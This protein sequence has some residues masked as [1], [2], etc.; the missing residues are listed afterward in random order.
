MN[1]ASTIITGLADSSSAHSIMASFVGPVVSTMCV[2]ASLACV[3]FLI[4]GGLTYMTSAGKPESLDHAKRVLKNALI[5]LI[6]VLAAGVLVQILTHAY[7]GSSVAIS[8]KLPNLTPVTPNPVSN[9][10]IDILIKAI[11][12]FLN[13]IIQ[14]IATPFL[15]AL[16]FF[17]SH[18]P[19]MADNSAVFNLWLAIVGITDALFVLVVA[20]LGFHVMSMSTFG[21][22]EIE[23]KHFVPRLALIFLGVNLSIFAID[24]IIELSNAMIHAIT[25]ISASTNIWNTMTD[26]VKQSGGAGVATLLVMVTFLIL[27]FILLVY[28]VGRIVALYV[29]AVLSPLVLML[30]LIP[31]FKDFS[32]TAAKVYISIIFV[33]FVNVIILELAASLFAGLVA[34]S[35]TH[36]P[37]T[38]MAMVTGIATLIALLKTQGVMREFS[39]ASTGPRMARKLGSQF[40]TGISFL[41]AKGSS[42]TTSTTSSKKTVDGVATSSKRPQSANSSYTQPGSNRSK[43]NSSS[44]LK[45][46]ATTVAPKQDVATKP[47]KSID[48]ASLNNPKEK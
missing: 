2:I 33:L 43:T 48:K 41:A 14:S 18:T 21:L 8:A 25:S 32:E 19:L 30:W 38:L 40:V 28:Y 34:N 24:G 13:N 17:T 3:F 7:A 1:Q 11:T 39:Y 31:G 23:L 36:V 9:G 26:V 12:G 22:D 29:G 4:N 35:P 16:S 42:K 6:I 10:L 37:N 44:K 45:T 20:L 46:G 15:A 47:P 5:G 27:S